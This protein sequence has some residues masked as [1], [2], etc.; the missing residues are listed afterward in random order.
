MHIIPASDYFAADLTPSSL[1][2]GKEQQQG[3]QG[4]QRVR[5]ALRDNGSV[6]V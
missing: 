6:T 4:Q 2:G 1:A 5:R 3:Q